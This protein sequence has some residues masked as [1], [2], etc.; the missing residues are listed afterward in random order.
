ML[1][2]LTPNSD[3]GD[4]IAAGAVVLTTFV[5]L[6][7]IRFGDSWSSGPRFL[8]VGAIATVIGTLAV[9]AP[10][11]GQAPRP[12]QSILYIAD[13]VLTLL[14]LGEL[15][16]VLGA[17][18]QLSASGTIVWV[19]LLLIGLAGFYATSRRSSIM[20]L[21][22]AATGVVVV[23]AFF[24]W[25]ANPSVQ[26]HRWLLLLCAIALGLGA[27]ALRDLRRRDAVSLVDVAGLSIAVIGIT[28]VLVQTIGAAIRSTP[29]GVLGSEAHGGPAGWEFVL[30]I[31]GFGLIAY[32]AIDRERVPAFI[33]VVVL[34]LFVGVAA[35]GSS[36]SLLWWPILLLLGGGAL[37]A[38]G[39]RP[40][41]ALPPE[42]PVPPAPPTA[43]TAVAGRH[44]A[45]GGGPA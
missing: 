28:L 1:A 19:G 41:G 8:V 25:V 39:M 42:P 6:F 7:D 27:V 17:D 31:T 40:R 45:E 14:A 3:R 30:L 37:L 11:E 9:L 43:P 33:G 35:I 22:A 20:T 5:L 4:V 21:L 18:N 44:A 10:L 38:A 36:A 12:Y 15:A 26:T 24:D 13:F 16:D 29:L 2:R 32:G 34:G 23:N